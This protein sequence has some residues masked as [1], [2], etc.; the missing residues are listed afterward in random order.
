MKQIHRRGFGVA[1]VLTAAMLAVFPSVETRA[2]SEESLI[3]VLNSYLERNS[4]VGHRSA[5]HTEDSETDTVTSYETAH[6]LAALEKEYPTSEK[7]L[8]LIKRLLTDSD[9]TVRCKAARVLGAIHAE[10][11]EPDLDAICSLLRSTDTKEVE[12][13]LKALRGLKAANAV[14]KILPVLTSRDTHNLRDACRTLAV[15][16]NKDLIAAIE[17]LLK[18]SDPAVRKDADAAIAVLRTK[19]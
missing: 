15:V 6:A 5:A 10:V 2:A 12:D 16:G 9:K 17:P 3:K 8:P 1:V 4:R 11:T 7:A 13:G 18:H 14:P 19:P